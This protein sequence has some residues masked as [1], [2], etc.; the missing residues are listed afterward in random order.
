MHYSKNSIKDILKYKNAND[1][2]YMTD[3]AQY[4]KLDI[5]EYEST[6]RGWELQKLLGEIDAGTR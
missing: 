6:Q 3:I 2:P 5:T 4:F 1:L